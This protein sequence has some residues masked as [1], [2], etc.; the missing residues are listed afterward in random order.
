M[1]ANEELDPASA[2]QRLE[3]LPAVAEVVWAIVSRFDHASG[4][5]RLLI[6]SAEARAGTTT[7]AAAT[8]I[9]LARHQQAPVCLVETSV[10]RPAVARYLG[11][12]AAGL[13]D[14]LDGRAQLDALLQSPLGCPRL[15]VLPA[16]TPRAAV[17]GEFT[18]ERWRAILESIGESHHY[19]VIDAPPVLDHV[20][21]RLLLQQSDGAFLV[22]HAQSTRRDAAERAHRILLEAGVPALG[23]VFN[24]YRPGRPIDHVGT[25][26][27]IGEPQST[28]PEPP[29]TVAAPSS[30]G[31]H[32]ADGSESDHVNGVHTWP[33][34][35]MVTP[36]APPPFP[37]GAI[38]E[39]E[40][41]REVDILE[42]RIA[43]LSEQL[44]HTESSLQ[45]IMAMKSTDSGIES[46][47]RE[48]QG[49]SIEDQAR[50]QKKELLQ[51]I[52]Q[53]NQ[54]LHQ[55]LALRRSKGSGVVDRATS[56]EMG[57]RVA[58]TGEA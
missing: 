11:L 15:H 28:A 18:T 53:A 52:F 27:L 44:A 30:N 55:T 37:S 6:T 31:S 21:S 8:A 36:A 14:L 35:R 42:R 39:E 17:A 43:K 7:I 58:A 29:T 57:F 45:R 9:A 41:R 32:A 1:Y 38:S 5:V 50:A 46:I 13:T 2:L 33:P 23:A 19:V 56:R 16:G 54:E 10:E 12:R 49:L 20:E 4:P 47:Y 40:H 25:Y 22:L 48:V 34:E 24:A 3:E 51:Q 26:Q